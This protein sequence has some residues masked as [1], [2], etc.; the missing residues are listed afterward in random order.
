MQAFAQWTVRRRWWVIGGWLVLVLALTALARLSGGAVYSN[1]FRFTGYD[2]QAARVL[3]EQQFPS[4]AGDSDQIVFHTTAGK[5]TDPAVHETVQAMIARVA[6]LPHVVGV[7]DPYAPP[8]QAIARDGATG[9][10]TVTF[11][12][13]ANGLPEDAV[14]RVIDS[15]RAARTATLQVE[16]GGQAIEQTVSAGPGAATFAGL[17]AAVLVLLLLFGSVTAMLMPIITALL[18]ILAGTQVNALI[19][20]ALDLNSATEAIALMIAL[21][22]GIDYSLFVVSRYRVLLAEGK[23]PRTAAAQSV[24]TSGRA[25]L[26]AGCLVVLALLGMLLLRVTITDAIAVTAAVEVALTMTAAI[27]L[28]PAMLSLLGHRVNSL[29]VPGRHPGRS[30][31]LDAWV[32]LVR[33]R[34][35]LFA[36][37]VT[38]LLVALAAPIATMRLG[39]S[40]AGADPANSTTYKAYTL[41]ANGF[42]PGVNGPLI[43]AVAMPGPDGAAALA[44][45][46]TAVRADRGVSSVS[47]P[48][49][50][51]SGSAAVVEVYPRTSPQSA[52]TSDLVHRLRDSVIP[53]ATAGTGL[54][55]H[56]GG[57]TATFIDLSSLLA[58]RLVPFVAV[59]VAIGFLVLLV[60]FRS[61]AI[62][63]TAA[64]LN[65]LSVT[66]ALGVVVAVF[67]YGWTGLPTGPV[68]FA[69]P[70]M[71]FAIVFGLSTDYQV[72]LL[73]NMHQE[74]RAHHDNDRAVRTGMR[75]VSGI[76]TGAALIMVAVFGSFVL[77]GQRLLEEIGVGLAVAVA[78][79]AFLIRFILVPAVMFIIGR[80]NWLLPRRLTWLP[81]LHAEPE[82]PPVEPV[83]AVVGSAP[84]A[85]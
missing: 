32:G 29:K 68:Q 55:V 70:V 33:R 13:D 60:Q 49:T 85:R 62:P 9:F 15:A 53:R 64:A 45:L 37:A 79:D 57:P 18:A 75:R 8:G 3:L 48:H 56:V 66:A 40:D 1:D 74:W 51:P 44:D 59:V 2:S 6:R 58:S 27:T 78:L 46:A 43:L 67:Q 25:V 71:M 22:V 76:I 30:L 77:G 17:A 38:G 36:V 69:L 16:L 4:A 54:V 12:T 47:P 7:S 14:T 39:S 63:L 31:R 24:N 11:D 61:V 5:V 80:R 50:D 65:L 84:R 21:G 10:A 72:F 35:W 73:T 52:P 34:R 26:S 28:L 20:R 42:G 83:P 23:E 82:S 19:S 81:R 41:L